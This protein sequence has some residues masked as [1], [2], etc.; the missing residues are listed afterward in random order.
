MRFLYIIFLL[1]IVLPG[2][3]GQFVPLGP[4]GGPSYNAAALKSNGTG[5]IHCIA[6][7]P[8][9]PK[10]NLI[11]AGSVYGGLWKST[12]GGNT[13]SM[14]DAVQHLEVNSVND[15]AMS[16]SEGKTTIYIATGS[17]NRH[18]P[19]VPSCGVYVS[20][21]MGESFTPLSSF[22][23]LNGGFRFAAQKLVTKIAIHPTDSR[24][25][26]IASSDG[27]Y[28]STNAG[29][30]WKLVLQEDEPEPDYMT[31]YNATETPGIFSVAFSPSNPRVIY[32]SGKE[33]YRS[34]RAGAE[35]TF[36]AMPITDF[37]ENAPRSQSSG[38]PSVQLQTRHFN[39]KVVS[40]N[41][42]DH[43]FCTA[44]A[45]YTTEGNKKN[46][47]YRVYHHNGKQWETCSTANLLN[48]GNNN[49]A[50]GVEFCKI[51]CPPGNP[52]LLITGRTESRISTDL[53]KT[54][55]TLT[56][57]CG[58]AHADI[59]EIK[60][61]P[62]GSMALLG[63]DGGIYKYD[64]ATGAVTEQNNGLSISMC[65]GMATS[66]LHPYHIAAGYQ[67]NGVDWY[68]GTRWIQTNLTGDGYPALW[69]DR[70]EPNKFYCSV[71]WSLMGINTT[72]RSHQAVSTGCNSA[73]EQLYQFPQPGRTHEF[74]SRKNGDKKIYYTSNSNHA[75]LHDEWIVITDPWVHSVRNFL[76]PN[77]APHHLYITTFSGGFWNDALLRRYDLEHLDRKKYDSDCRNTPLC[78]TDCYR[79]YKYLCPEVPAEKFN[80][81]KNF[82]PASSVAISS[83]DT[84]KMWV[85]ISYDEKFLNHPRYTELCN[86][87][88]R[89]RLLRS[90]D[91]GEH[92]ENDDKGIPEYP[93]EEVI[94][95]DGSDDALFCCT[96][97]GRIF[98]KNAQMDSWTEVDPALP[99]S[100]I[101]K[102]EVNYC[103]NRLYI[104]TY[105]RGVFYLD[106]LSYPPHRNQRLTIADNTVWYN[107]YCDIGSDVLIKS[108]NELRI[109]GS[110]VNVC[111][112]CQ[113]I[114]EPGASLVVENSTLYNTC[115][116]AWRGIVVSE[117]TNSK[118]ILPENI[119]DGEYKSW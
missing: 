66:P 47:Y 103:T 48:Q 2:L 41:G 36:S 5:Q 53:G 108:G 68:D 4:V 44:L 114:I 76:I 87:G 49:G 98:Y 115:G 100:R 106:L 59:R 94:Y 69:W 26:F 83:A 104:S 34:S 20:T 50:D 1:F 16:Y 22:N 74:I 64:V 3:H 28:R 62:D 54:W 52:Y 38:M 75:T 80:G 97:N 55:K 9:Y 51:D 7:H 31:N 43:I 84:N 96:K 45:V 29:R 57:Y 70:K 63:T 78:T 92:W 27:L 102:M 40:H 15:I 118:I 56:D 30:T 33:I 58:N 71:N 111:R 116:E 119:R 37:D 82:Y 91:G 17:S 6:F 72:R 42:T 46:Y 25:L 67:D 12:D 60:F 19:W 35:G 8:D 112:G 21:D 10:T 39:F 85:A 11:L 14:V 77:I 89:Y 86:D 88:Y 73:V 109:T 13:W 99:R 24:I 32:A 117:G 110:W 90:T 18:W 95:V 23:R 65:H 93:V 107:R 105:G 81:C 79:D 101:T 113:I 61:S